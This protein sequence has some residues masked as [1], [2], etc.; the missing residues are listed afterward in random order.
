MTKCTFNC[1]IKEDPEDRVFYSLYKGRV[2]HGACAW[3]VRMD[4]L[5][6]RGW[7]IDR[8]YVRGYVKNTDGRELSLHELFTRDEYKIETMHGK[9]YSA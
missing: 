7:D 5:R 8:G 2:Y 3:D 1:N 6:K 9:K 4:D